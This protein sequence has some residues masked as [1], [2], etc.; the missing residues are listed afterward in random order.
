MAAGTK[1]L[2]NDTSRIVP[3]DYGER[4][5]GEW[6][7]RSFTYADFTSTADTINLIDIPAN[8]F[9]AEMYYVPKVVFNGTTP[10]LMIGDEDNDDEYMAVD[11]VTEDD[12]E[13]AS[14][15]MAPDATGTYALKNGRRFYAA[16]NHVRVRFDWASG[17]PTTGEGC[18]IACIVEVP[19]Y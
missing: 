12:V 7:A 6:I 10:Q 3:V 2:S 5:R 4:A 15:M 11:E 18:V 14:D 19:S 9:V 13:L 16:A 17:T 1:D 8:S